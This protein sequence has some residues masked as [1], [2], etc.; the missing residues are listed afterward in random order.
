MMALPMLCPEFRRAS[1]LTYWLRLDLNRLDYSEC[2][3]K[4]E[5]SKLEQSLLVQVLNAGVGVG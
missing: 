4:R 5:A 2:I 3:S 1:T